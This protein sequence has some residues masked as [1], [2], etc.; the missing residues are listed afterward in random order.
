MKD[1]TRGLPQHAQENIATRHK[2]LADEFIKE[3]ETL[4]YNPT[5]TEVALYFERSAFGNRT[6][7]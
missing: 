7:D 5:P 6:R 1:E 4:G 3:C 2:R